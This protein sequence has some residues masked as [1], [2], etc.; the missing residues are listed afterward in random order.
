MHHFSIGT[1]KIFLR[2]SDSMPRN[3]FRHR[4]INIL[5]RWYITQKNG[6]RQTV[7]V[8]HEKIWRRA[9]EYLPK[10][11]FCENHRY[12]SRSPSGKDKELK[13][14]EKR[15]GKDIYK[16]KTV[17]SQGTIRCLQ[18]EHREQCFLLSRRK[19]AEGAQIKQSANDLNLILR[20]RLMNFWKCL[21]RLALARFKIRR[22]LRCILRYTHLFRTI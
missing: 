5:D 16:R 14:L 18:E 13:K 2:L 15:E 7:Q 8:V 17:L 20:T 3:R 6:T 1:I 4:L 11:A 10:V 22:D 9:S 21:N 19:T 12:C